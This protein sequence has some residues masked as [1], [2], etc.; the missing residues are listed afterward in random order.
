MDGGKSDRVKG[1]IK[2]S[3]GVMTDD[4]R[5]KNEGRVDQAAGKVKDKLEQG[6]DKVK[7]NINEANRDRSR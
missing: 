2:E 1:K 5:L 3:V 6:V 7:D 4:S